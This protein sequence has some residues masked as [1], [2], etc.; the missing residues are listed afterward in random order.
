[1]VVLK[2]VRRV[3][4]RF[5]RKQCPTLSA[6]IAFYMTLAAIPVILTTIIIGGQVIIGPERI[7]EQ[8]T[9]LANTHFPVYTEPILKQV[10]AL[11]EH[12]ELFVILAIIILTWTATSMFAAFEFA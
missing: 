1:M 8:V 6:S 11:S 2:F 9:Q 10:Y 5:I 4:R 12:R 3:F 7:I